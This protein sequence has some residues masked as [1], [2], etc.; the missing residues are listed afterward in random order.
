MWQLEHPELAKI[1]SPAAAGDPGA[2]PVKVSPVIDVTA[3]MLVLPHPHATRA[4]APRTAVH[5][6]AEVV[7]QTSSDS[8]R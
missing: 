4:T 1:A 3:V 6:T 2:I 5:N 8:P 7:A